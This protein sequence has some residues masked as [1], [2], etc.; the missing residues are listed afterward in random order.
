MAMSATIIFFNSLWGQPL[1]FFPAILDVGKPVASPKTGTRNVN[2]AARLRSTC[3][4]ARNHSQNQSAVPGTERTTR[5]M[6]DRVD[7]TSDD[8]TSVSIDRNARGNLPLPIYATL[9]APDMQ[10]DRTLRV[11]AGSAPRPAAPPSQAGSNDQ[12][13]DLI[14]G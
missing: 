5:T 4:S 3:A 9:S 1:R 11:L 8:T 2:A 7:Q 10:R 12:R 14:A 6:T 13:T